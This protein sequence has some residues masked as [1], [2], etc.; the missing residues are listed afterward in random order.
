M[1]TVIIPARYGS[2]RLPGKPLA[3]IAGKT[4]VQRVYERALSSDANDVVIATDD[5]RVMAAAAGFGAKCLMTRVDHESGTDRLQEA[6]LALGL[7]DSDIVVNV[8]GDEPLIP[9]ENIN[10]VY[11][12]IVANN[13]AIA[14][15]SVAINDVE[16]YNDLNAV[17]VVSATDGT[18]LYF[19]RA[20]IPFVRDTPAQ[21][22]SALSAQRHVGI[23]A[24]KVS[25]LNQFVNWPASPLE[26]SERLEQLRAMENGEKI[27]VAV[28]AID[29]P[30]GVDTEADLLRLRALL[31]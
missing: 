11:A 17:K 4:M 24:Y 27:H 7:T 3:D 20:A 30:A 22:P 2:T 5:E 18:A 21:L 12:N 23:Y 10:Q 16:E 13:T 28:A 14:T 29:P 19:S 31:A 1:F 26:L 9:P 8:Q 25:L 15:L 6:A